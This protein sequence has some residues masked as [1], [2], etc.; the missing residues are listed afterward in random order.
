MAP[1]QRR[2]KNGSAHGK[3]PR[4]LLSSDSPLDAAAIYRTTGPLTH[5]EKQGLIQLTIVKDIT[6]CD[7]VRADLVLLQRPWQAKDNEILRMCQYFDVPVWIDYDD[8]LWE[9]PL[10]H[11]SKIRF[12]I[13]AMMAAV[14]LCR[15]KLVTTSTPFLRQK[16][17]E[18]NNGDQIDIPLLVLP[19]TLDEER[20][21]VIYPEVRAREKRAVVW[22]GSATHDRDL[23]EFWVHLN[24]ISKTE[25][26]FYFG[27][28]SSVI[29]SILPRG[30]R[31]G[32]CRDHIS[33]FRL[34]REM[35]SEAKVLIVPLSD[36]AF[37]RSKSH[38]SVLEAISA[39]IIPVVPEWLD[40]AQKMGV[41]T[42]RDENDF[43]QLTKKVLKMGQK[44]YVALW[45][46]I[47]R[48][49]PKLDDYLPIY[50]DIIQLLIGKGNQKR[51][52]RAV[53]S[54]LKK[55]GPQSLSK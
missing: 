17:F 24:E 25:S 47:Y 32:I 4:I 1:H 2:K 37:N 9:L 27:E 40:Q 23:L 26:I 49:V 30:K 50:N 33:F 48:K 10:G 18:V 41:P 51:S 14:S 46:S 54:R 21:H 13:E 42:Y 5:L 29:A 53:E 44:E 31:G 52:V 15:K 34:N 36:H 6:W 8:L 3:R 43:V 38:C 39:G 28:V 22:R 11:P 7:I 55:L 45:E 20:I 12:N 35:S 19:N 16:L